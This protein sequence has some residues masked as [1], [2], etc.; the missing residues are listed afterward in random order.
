MDLDIE[1]C[2][3]TLLHQ[4]ATRIRVSPA[5]PPGVLD[6][7]ERC[8]ECRDELAADTLGTS[9][10]E[11]K[12]LL[13]A[14]FNGEQPTGKWRGHEFV[15]KV[16]ILGR[17]MRWFA[18]SL[19]PE[20][21]Q[22][23]VANVDCEWPQ[24]SCLYFM[25]TALEDYILSSII[26][27]LTAK[28]TK[29]LS[30]HYD[31]VRVQ[32]GEAIGNTVELCKDIGLHVARETGFAIRVKEKVH[33]TFFSLLQAKSE[34]PSTSSV[35]MPA[36]LRADGQCIFAALHMLGRLPGEA[37]ANLRPSVVATRTY[38]DALSQA[39]VGVKDISLGLVMKTGAH[40]L[41]HAENGG[42]PHCVAARRDGSRV[43]IWDE[44]R[45]RII[46]YDTLMACFMDGTDKY[47]VVTVT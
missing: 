24:A 18:C 36:P 20:V 22:E 32:F 13:T 1:S 37:L 26:N 7:L 34:A 11:C 25:W 27:F 45:E 33:S 9:V 39:K 41:I 47:S 23:R 29:H 40:C 12:A 42:R 15:S 8:A 5:I 19:L 2:M 6:T 30:L 14:V 43:T 38:V 10:A 21:L 35:G 16:R 28:P 46:Q 44:D 3:F 17:H 4:I 31:G